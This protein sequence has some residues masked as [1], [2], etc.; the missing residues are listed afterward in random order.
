VVRKFLAALI[1]FLLAPMV[2]TLLDVAQSRRIHEVVSTEWWVMIY[3]V[4]F[5]SICVVGVPSLLL[6]SAV[7]LIRWWSLAIVGA[8]IGF[9]MVRYMPAIH[10]MQVNMLSSAIGALCGVVFWTILELGNEPGE[11]DG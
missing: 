1:A 7:R 3:G 11:H 2:P 8:G 6:L 5:V 4:S 10:Q 9:V